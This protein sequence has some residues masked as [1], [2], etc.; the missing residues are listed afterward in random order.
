MKEASFSKR[1]EFWT[2]IIAEQRA[3]GFSQAK[4]CESRG[5]SKSSFYNWS[6]ILKKKNKASFASVQVTKQ[7]RRDL[8]FRLVFASGIA[9]H[10][11]E[12][13]D[14]AWIVELMRLVS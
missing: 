11:V 1:Q 9:L 13:P 4:F 2:T 7:E 12:K 5:I 6:S 8:R 3:S 14:P 10:F